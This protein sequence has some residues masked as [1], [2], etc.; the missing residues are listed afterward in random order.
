MT[1]QSLN[2]VTNI[3]ADA[4]N[5]HRQKC[6]RLSIALNLEGFLGTIK[7]R[8]LPGIRSHVSP[9]RGRI[10]TKTLSNSHMSEFAL[11]IHT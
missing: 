9:H 3:E 7:P 10:S 8:E 1:C 5:E 6:S 2:S 4:R 11:F